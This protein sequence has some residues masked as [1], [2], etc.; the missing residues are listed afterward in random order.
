MGQSWDSGLLLDAKT[1]LCSPGSLK[2]PQEHAED[3]RRQS[4][5]LLSVPVYPLKVRW[6][7]LKAPWLKMT[8]I[9][10]KIAISMLGDTSPMNN[11]ALTLSRS[12]P[13]HDWFT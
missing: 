11:P 10:L 2:P 13:N 1:D 8:L 4:W 9:P 3:I 6:T 7:H 5:E 12:P